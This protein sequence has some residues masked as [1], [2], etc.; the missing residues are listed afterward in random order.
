[1]NE[2]ELSNGTT[3]V[4]NTTIE[5]AE[6]IN[7]IGTVEAAPKTAPFKAGDEVIVHHNVFRK[8]NGYEGVRLESDYYLE[9]NLYYVT[10]DLIFAYK[11]PG[12]SWEALEPYFFVKP[13][14]REIK[15]TSS[16]IFLESGKE[17]Y[18]HQ[19]ASLRYL[20]KELREWGLKEGDVVGYGKNQEYKFNIDGELLYRVRMPMLLYKRCKD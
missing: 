6:H 13:I 11:S 1:L 10:K 7:R 18:V 5:S 16:G 17:K 2:V 12:G 3:L 4:V 14:E 15:K 8:K 20:N 19:E 9:P